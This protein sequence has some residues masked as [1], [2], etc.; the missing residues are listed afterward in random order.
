MK[1]VATLAKKV[2]PQLKVSNAQDEWRVYSVDQEVEQLKKGNE[3]TIS[4][5][6]YSVLSLL[7]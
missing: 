5:E 3:L 1:A 2:Q 4:G 6:L 7:M